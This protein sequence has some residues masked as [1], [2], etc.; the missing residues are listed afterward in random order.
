[1]TINFTQTSFDPYDR[2][3]YEVVLKSGKKILFNNWEETQRY[4]FINCQIP[5]FLDYVEVKF[6]GKGFKNK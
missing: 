2:H 5:D 6:K 1:M 4:W 3:D